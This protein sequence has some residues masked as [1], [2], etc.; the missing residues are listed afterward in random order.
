MKGMKIMKVGA[1][2]PGKFFMESFHESHEIKSN[3][4][5]PFMFFMFFMVKITNF[6]V[7]IHRI[8][9]EDAGC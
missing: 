1:L 9:T 6:L 3:I 2:K 5:K 4:F 7:T 8:V